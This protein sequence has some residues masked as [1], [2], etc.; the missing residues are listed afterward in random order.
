MT[1]EAG[2]GLPDCAADLREGVDFLP[3]Y[4]A[5]ATNTPAAG[6]FT[7][8]SPWNFPFA[9]FLGQ[10][11]AAL[12]ADNAFLAKPTEQT[13]L[14]AHMAI[15]ILHDAG[16][17]LT[18]LQMLL[19]GCDVGVAFTGSTG[20]AQRIGATMADHCAPGIPL[21]A[22]TG[23]LN[24]RI[25]DSTALPEQ[26]VQAIVESAFQ[27]VGQRCCALRCL[28]VQEHIAEEFQKKLIGAMQ[29]LHMSDP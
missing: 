16:V 5:Q 14:I 29:A 11:C 19:G 8:I 12:A 20:T 17:P 28:Y 3:S 9:I 7:C 23:G 27:S 24:P 15:G 21:I 6:V 1:R 22:E 4:A 25:V 18:V 2:K 13:P 26:A 10:I